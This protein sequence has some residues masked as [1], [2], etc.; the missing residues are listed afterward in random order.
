[1]QLNA[2]FLYIILLLILVLYYFIIYGTDEKEK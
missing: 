1:M 2:D